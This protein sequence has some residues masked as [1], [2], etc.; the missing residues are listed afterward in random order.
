MEKIK[1]THA[2]PPRGELP[3]APPTFDNFWSGIGIGPNGAM[4]GGQYGGITMIRDT[5]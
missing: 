1:S 4:Y 2:M 5:R 3:G